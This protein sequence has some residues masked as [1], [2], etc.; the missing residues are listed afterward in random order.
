MVW[1]NKGKLGS[2]TQGEVIAFVNYI[3]QILLAL[4][5]FAQLIV[6]LTKASTSATRVSEIL[7]IKSTIVEKDNIKTH[8]SKSE[9]E[10]IEFKN[11]FFFHMLTLMNIH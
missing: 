5:V 2:L 11:V 10:F 9:T 4:I 3:T 1:W 8:S 6:T 7:E